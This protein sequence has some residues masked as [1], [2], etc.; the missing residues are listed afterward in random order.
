MR[1]T[2]V[3]RNVFQDDIDA[4]LEKVEKVLKDNGQTGLWTIVNNA[5]IEPWEGKGHINIGHR[6]S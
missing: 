2:A 5:A 6:H 1:T 3:L 4:C